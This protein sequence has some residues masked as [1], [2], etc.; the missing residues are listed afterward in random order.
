MAKGGVSSSAGAD[1]INALPVHVPVPKGVVN[2]CIDVG[3]H[4]IGAAGVRQIVS[5]L[6]V[7]MDEIPVQIRGLLKA[8]GFYLSVIPRPGVERNNEGLGFC[9]RS[10]TVIGRLA[11]DVD[12]FEISRPV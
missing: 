4:Q 8:T 7:G 9:A 12:F 6:M 1:N 10:W 5:A 11:F 2:S 3:Y